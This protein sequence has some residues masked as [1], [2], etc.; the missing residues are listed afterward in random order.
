MVAGSEKLMSPNRLRELATSGTAVGAWCTLPTAAVSETVALTG[1]DYVCID[2]Q[3]GLVDYAAMVMMLHGMART[4]VTSIVRVAGHDPAVI[5]KVLDAGAD[6]V[7]VPMVEDAEQAAR[8]AA[9]CRYPPRGTRSYGPVRAS[10]VV[11]SGD[12]DVLNDHV[13]CFVMIETEAGVENADE[14]CATPGVDG[15][16]IGPAD[17]AV[18]FGER[19]GGLIPGRHADAVARV[20]DCCR[21]HGI[22]PAIHAYDGATARRYAAMGFRMVTFGVDLRLLRDSVARELAAAR[23]EVTG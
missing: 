23:D 10:A 17:L 5:G 18:S 11:G 9:A 20:L 21:N 6:A 16:Y 22:I 3:H 8:V 4:G 15:V 19:P 12:V 13:M 1:P 7:I 14:I 2:C